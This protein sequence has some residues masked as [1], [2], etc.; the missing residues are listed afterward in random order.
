L[1]RHRLAHSLPFYYGWVIFSIGVLA[2]YSSRP[3]MA[4]ATLSVF[5]VPMTREFG[6][7]YGLFSG[8][9][10]LGGLCA[11]GISPFVGRLIDRYGSGVILAVTSAIVGSCAFGLSLIGQAW[12]F[13]ALYVPGR[14]AFASPLELGT[15]TAINNWFIRRRSFALFLLTVS[16]ST[17]LAAMP[18]VADFLIGGWGW[19]NAWAWLGIFTVVVGI[20]PALL[21]VSRRPEDMGLIPDPRRGEPRAFQGQSGPPNVPSVEGPGGNSGN[22]EGQE[23]APQ[24]PAQAAADLGEN[25]YTVSRALRTRAF[26]VMAVFSGAGFMVQAGV[27]LHQTAHYVDAGVSHGQAA[28]VATAFALGQIPGGMAWSLAGRRLPVRVTL[29][30]SAVW[31]AGGVF[32]IGFTHQLAWGIAFGFLFGAGVGGLHTL[33]RLAWADYY[34]RVHLGAIRGL[35]LPAQIGGQAIGP[36]VSGFMFDASGGYLVPFVIF[37]SAVALSAL[38]VLAA[39]PPT[40]RAAAAGISP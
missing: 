26:Y 12:A 20:L 38:L 8:V 13:Y 11:I 39:V 29:A 21:L 19:R 4:V 6:W 33:L 7:S 9:V 22:G 1:L 14:M 37:G 36:V 34:G 16:Q 3:L 24:P 10:S 30:I 23:G 17:G 35:T 31:L 2:S 18:L 32:G 27:S 28:L 5:A 15:T 25:S 40:R